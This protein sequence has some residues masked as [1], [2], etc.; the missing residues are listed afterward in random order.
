ME[1]YSAIQ[2]NEVQATA[3]MD[4][5]HIQTNKHKQTQELKNNS[6]K[7]RILDGSICMKSPA[8]RKENQ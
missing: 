1:R 8:E 5:K 4:L 3:W 7:D 2:M 6:M